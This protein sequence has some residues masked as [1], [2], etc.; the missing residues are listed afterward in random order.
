MQH[1]DNDMDDLFKRAGENYPLRKGKG[2]W[3]YISKRLVNNSE[4]TNVLPPEKKKSK[5]VIF[6]MLLV[7]F[8]SGGWLIYNNFNAKVRSV[9]NEKQ[10]AKEINTQDQT[11]SKLNE[12]GLGNSETSSLDRSN[13]LPVSGAESRPYEKKQAAFSGKNLSKVNLATPQTSY[14]KSENNSSVTNSSGQQ[15]NMEESDLNQDVSGN[16][17]NSKQ[18]VLDKTETRSTEN[19]TGK[20]EVTEANEKKKVTKISIRKKKGLYFGIAAGPDYSKVKAQ[21]FSRTGYNAG[22]LLGY[23]LNSKFSMEA[24]VFW[25]KKNYTSEGA[26]FNIEKV[27]STMP[28]GMVIDNLESQCFVTEIPLKIKY[29]FIRKT[30]S[31]LFIAGGVSSYVMTKEMN[32]YDATLNGATEKLTGIYKKNVYDVPAVAHIGL[33]FEHNFF[34]YFDIRI[35]PYLKIPLRG[36][37]VGSLPVSSA[38]LQL[39]ITGRLK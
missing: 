13:T 25:N 33:G 28:S 2:N 24:G 14:L 22:L 4:K 30:N 32:F 7:F 29:D 36:M 34:R 11:K 38:G 9:S 19:L 27:R 23:R 1:L 6:L 15:L 39:G 18:E 3:E 26:Y 16:S 35:E 12:S 8:L 20:K 10:T 5:K 37:G 21:S 31:D 17:K